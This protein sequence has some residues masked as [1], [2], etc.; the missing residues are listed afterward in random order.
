[1]QIFILYCMP[2]SHTYV[3]EHMLLYYFNFICILYSLM[4]MSDCTRSH[5]I[6]FL[7]DAKA[8]EH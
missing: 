6:H 3:S 1:M 7:S 8:D 5:L 4:K 2:P